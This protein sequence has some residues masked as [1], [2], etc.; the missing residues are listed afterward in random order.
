[1]GLFEP[2]RFKD[3]ELIVSCGDLMQT[4]LHFDDDTCSS[5]HVHGNHDKSI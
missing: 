3:I 5:N 2:E 1:M 4:I